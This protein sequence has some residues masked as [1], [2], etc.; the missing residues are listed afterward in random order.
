M[1]ACADKRA[2][3]MVQ[4]PGRKDDVERGKEAQKPAKEGVDVDGVLLGH[5]L[6]D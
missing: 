5:G 3:G 2:R 4:R 6:I 1:H